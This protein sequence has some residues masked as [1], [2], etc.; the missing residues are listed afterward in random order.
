M[1]T[2][3]NGMTT[4]QEPP[5]GPMGT[6]EPLIPWPTFILVSFFLFLLPYTPILRFLKRCAPTPIHKI[7]KK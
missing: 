1:D 5:Q 7:Q 2:S 6:H 4:Y 3:Y